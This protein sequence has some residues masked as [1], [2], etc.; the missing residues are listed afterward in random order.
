MNLF[1][2]VARALAQ[3]VNPPSVPAPPARAV[4]KRRAPAAVRTGTRAVPDARP[5][6]EIREWKRNGHE[7]KGCYR[8]TFGSY[9]GLIDVSSV[10]PQFFIVNPPASVLNGPHR[11]CFR[12]RGKGLYFVHFGKSSFDIDAGIA[13]VERLIYQ[14]LK[15]RRR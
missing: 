14:S 11:A 4:V 15:K 1:D 3:P 12:P 10:K 2:A 13:A 5:L 9:E 8:T 7:F 6:V